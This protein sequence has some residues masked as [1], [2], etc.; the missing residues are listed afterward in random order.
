MKN[1]ISWGTGIVISFTVFMGITISTGIYM[2]SLGVNL[3]ADDYYD[4][5]IKY[6]QQID[7]IERTK[8]FDNKNLI[9]YNGTTVKIELPSKFVKR[10]VTGEVYF[11]RPSD[12]TNDLKI[13]L[14]IDSLGNQIIPVTALDRGLWTVK[15]N[16]TLFEKEYYNEKRIFLE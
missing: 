1:K 5:E 6:Q 9:S 8:K 13:P 2:M 3:V 12:G 14:S 11:Y 16:W 15:V 4:Q 7:R 10:K